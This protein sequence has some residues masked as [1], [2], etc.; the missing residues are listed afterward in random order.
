M[1]QYNCPNNIV[2]LRSEY[3]GG[4]GLEIGF[5]DQFNTRLLTTLNYS[6]IPNLHTLQ[7]TAAHAK[8]V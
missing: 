3:R 2:T 1:P 8:S 6:A 5:N 4:F 7:I